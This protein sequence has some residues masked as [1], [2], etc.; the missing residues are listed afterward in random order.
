MALE[1]D[2]LFVCV[3]TLTW[4]CYGSMIPSPPSPPWSGDALSKPPM[5]AEG[6]CA[7]CGGPLP[8]DIAVAICPQCELR[9]AL[10]LSV[11][12]SQSLSGDGDAAGGS[13]DL[14]AGNSVRSDVYSLGAILYHLVTGRPPF[15]GETL[16][17]VLHQVVN[18]EPLDPH[19][20]SP[21]VPHDLETLSECEW[22]PPCI[23][24]HELDECGHE[25]PG[26]C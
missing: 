16:T 23:A 8:A 7:Q 17:D 12:P 25:H 14:A 5:N 21:R 9:G 10:R 4:S 19:L 13:S 2:H 11:Q 15:Q 20:L 6:Q 3:E 26:R 24:L 18:D 1:L 22:R